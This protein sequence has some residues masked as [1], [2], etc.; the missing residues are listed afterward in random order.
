MLRPKPEVGVVPVPLIVALVGSAAGLLFASVSTYDFVAHLDRQVH[1][2]HCSLLPG[3]GTPDATGTSGCHVTLMSPYSS[4]L[5]ESIWGGIPISARHGGV[6]VLAVLGRPAVAHGQDARRRA[7]GF[8]ALATAVP[9]SRFAGDG[10]HLAECARCRVQGV[11]RDL[12]L[13]HPVRGGRRAHVA[14]RQRPASQGVSMPGEEAQ[15]MSFGALGIAFLV[16]CLFVT[17]SVVAYAAGT[18]D[19]EK[20]AGTAASSP[21]SPTLARPRAPRWS[22]QR[23]ASARSARSAMSC[24]SCLRAAFLGTLH[25]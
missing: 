13:E 8:Y 23:P 7:T 6:R 1:G 22:G 24:L 19:F 25:P 5:R 16:G 17:V 18:P 15:R 21:S 3:L 10:H 2:L 11:P 12:P 4:V 14:A 20:Y 9:G